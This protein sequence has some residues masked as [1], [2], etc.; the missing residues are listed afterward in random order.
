MAAV[1]RAEHVAMERVVALKIIAPELLKH[2]LA[3]ARF[4]SEARAASSLRSQHVVQLYDYDVDP[5]LGPY[6][7]MELLDGE[8][9]ESRLQ[10]YGVLGP[11]DVTSILGQV[12]KGLARAHAVSIVHRDVKP[13][14]IFLVADEEGLEIAKLLDFGVAKV[15]LAASV[16]LTSA[17]L[18]VGTLS[19]MSPEQAMGQTIDHRSDLYSLGILAYQCLVGEIPFER[20]TVGAWLVAICTASP[21]VPSERRPDLPASF[22]TWFARACDRDPDRRFQ[23]ARELASALD[24]ALAARPRLILTEQPDSIPPAEASPA[25]DTHIASAYYITNSGTTVGPVEAVVLKRGIMAG[26]VPPASM[27]WRDGW[28]QWRPVDELTEE[29][30]S[31]TIPPETLPPAGNGLLALGRPSLFPSRAP[32]TL[33]VG[34]IELRSPRT[35]EFTAPPRAEPVRQN[36]PC[37]YVSDGEVV[38]G[39]V[40]GALLRKGVEKGRVEESAVVWRDGWDAWQAAGD[41]VRN[42]GPEQ[43]PS[44]QL[45]EGSGLQS[46]GPPSMLPR[47]APT[48]IRASVLRAPMISIMPEYYV[49]DGGTTVGPVSASLLRRGIEARRVPDTALVWTDGW[50]AWRPVLD[51][52]GDLAQ[53]AS[54][55]PEV[56]RSG[57]GIEALGRPSALPPRAPPTSRPRR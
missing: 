52:A 8:S 45:P 2:P 40:S 33:P 7:V 25:R 22:N 53:Y 56:L 11:R 51:I 34:K 4:R 5:V 47:A 32:T 18:L 19:H 10:R 29:L 55:A 48:I 20:N 6:I 31:V 43:D 12:C 26:K 3:L 23:S 36:D 21:P 42:L 38:V 17:G 9:L 27:I 41:V 37:Y 24:K 28:P 13:E 39:P 15:P 14:N 54:T 50:D 1:W 57:R 30:A 49:A 35:P 46:I 16:G 44:P